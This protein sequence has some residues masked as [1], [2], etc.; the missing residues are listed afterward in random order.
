[1]AVKLTD[2][3]LI[4]GVAGAR[5]KFE[6]LAVHLIKSERPDVERI[7]IV[8]GD[9]GID[10]HDGSLSDAGRVDVFQVK[11]FPEGIGE[12]QKNQIRESF[13]RIRENKELKAHSWTLCL[14]V[15]L[16]IDEKKWFDEWSEKQKHS[17]IEIRPVWGALTIESF[18]YHERNNGVREQFFQE[19][20]MR[21]I[22]EIQDTL[23]QLVRDFSERFPKPIPVILRANLTDIRSRRTYNYDA[24]SIVVEVVLVFSIL[25]L[26]RVSA[27]NWT[28]SVNIN[29]SSEVC[30]TRETFPA[31]GSGPSS[32]RLDKTI[33]PTQHM[34]EEHL[35][36]LKVKRAES[37][38][39]QVRQLLTPTTV[40][41]H[42]IS[43]DYVGETTSVLV[44]DQVD[45]NRLLTGVKESLQKEGIWFSDP[46]A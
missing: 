38:E 11:F 23:E 13:K 39:A 8:R 15:D 25:N 42:V 5:E 33:L 3:Q 36:G 2:L 9:G 28:V 22:R 31:I 29:L 12:S 24:E 14:P 10:A 27:K 44:R 6:D 16:S 43:D 41:F 26:G 7:R 20:H 34:T 37:V 45:W 40:T 32:I 21:R 4:Y 1:M 46:N 19:H 17:G 18:L 35:L 30:L